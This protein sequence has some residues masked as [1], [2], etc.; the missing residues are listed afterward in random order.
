ML[1]SLVYCRSRRLGILEEWVSMQTRLMERTNSMR[2]KR[3]LD[4]GGGGGD[5]EQPERKRPA[6]AR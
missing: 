5:D 2:G 4:G 6:L 1:C 3:S